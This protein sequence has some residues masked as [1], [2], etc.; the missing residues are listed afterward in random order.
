MVSTMLFIKG[1]RDIGNDSWCGSNK[2]FMIQYHF[3][4]VSL[5][6]CLIIASVYQWYNDFRKSFVQSRHDVALAMSLLHWS[7][8]VLMTW[9]NDFATSH[10]W[11]FHVVVRVMYSWLSAL[12]PWFI[13][14]M[15]RTGAH[16]MLDYFHTNATSSDMPLYAIEPFIWLLVV[17]Q[18]C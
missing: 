3:C 17:Y 6:S 2:D 4:S 1:H 18:L 8:D 7:C 5:K 13:P 10:V 9:L 12:C 11:Y 16:V 15:L 14:H